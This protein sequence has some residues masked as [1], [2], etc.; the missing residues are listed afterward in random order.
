MLPSEFQVG[1][2][3]SEG[4]EESFTAA[5]DFLIRSGGRNFGVTVPVVGMERVERI[6][7]KLLDPGASQQAN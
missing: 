4:A 2:C 1:F 7:E 3:L 5:F 6:D